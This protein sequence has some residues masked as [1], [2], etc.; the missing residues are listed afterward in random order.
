MHETEWQHF[1]TL[2]DQGSA[3]VRVGMLER[4]GVPAKVVTDGPLPGLETGYHVFVPAAL[5]HRAKWLGAQ[6]PVSDAELDYLATGE[7]NEEDQY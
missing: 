1:E 5:I 6:A 2:P 3:Q 7:L 4:G